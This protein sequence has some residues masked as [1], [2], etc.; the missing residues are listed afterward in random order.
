MESYATAKAFKMSTSL[1][2]LGLRAVRCEFYSWENTFSA[3]HGVC[4]VCVH[5]YLCSL[6]Q[7]QIE[8]VAQKL[9]PTTYF[10]EK[11]K[12]KKEAGQNADLSPQAAAELTQR[13]LDCLVRKGRKGSQ[14]TI[15]SA[16]NSD[17]L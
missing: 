9:L 1:S 8:N 3:M 5:E 12:K 11:K 17:A 6:F 10:I 14:P 7:K 13:A 2:V 4:S 16:N 15:N